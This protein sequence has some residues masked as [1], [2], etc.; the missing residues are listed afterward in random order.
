MRTWEAGDPEPSDHPAIVDDDSITWVWLEVED[1]FW[2]YIQTG[3]AI[4]GNGGIGAKALLWIDLLEEYGPAREA[5]AD[6]T[7][8]LDVTYR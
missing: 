4:N 2:C 6:E 3:V 5:T 1:G 8:A 7:A